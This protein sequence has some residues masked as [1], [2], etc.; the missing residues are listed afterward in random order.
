MKSPKD[1]LNQAMVRKPG[2]PGF[3]FVLMAR[4]LLFAPGAKWM[5]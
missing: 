1:F 2:A 5:P 4:F 3:I